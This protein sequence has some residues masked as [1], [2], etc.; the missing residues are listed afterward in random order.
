MSDAD[1]TRPEV[2]AVIPARGGSKG[3]PRKNLLDLGGLPL[4]AWSIRAALACPL[5]TRVV[6]ST[7]DD[8]IAAVAREHGAEVPFMRPVELAGDR[9][10]PHQA[11]THVLERLHTDEGYAPA[12]YCTLYP[13]HPFRPAGLVAEAAALA[14]EA[15]SPVVAARALGGGPYLAPEGDGWRPLDLGGP[16]WRTY[17]LVEA[18]SLIRPLRGVRLLPVAD[19]V[20]LIDIDTEADLALAREAVRTGLAVPPEVGR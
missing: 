8:E 5:V 13:T 1:G 14:L 11:V 4:L 16:A 20:A 9:S 18:K 7:E 15:Y 12:A 6:V 19:P 3:L 10:L 2:L 17:G